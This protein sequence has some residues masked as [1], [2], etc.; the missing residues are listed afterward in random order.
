MLVLD[1]TIRISIGASLEHK[2]FRAVRAQQTSQVPR[3]LVRRLR[4][5][6]ASSLLS[7]EAMKV[8][9]RQLPSKAISNLSVSPRQSY[10][11]RLDPQSTGFITAD[12][13]SEALD[14]NGYHMAVE[15][16]RQIVNTHS[17]LGQGRIK[18]SDFL[19]ATLDRREI[20]DEENLWIAFNYFD[21][22]SV[23]KLTIVSIFESLVRAGCNVS[24]EDIR[25]ISAEFG[26][27][28]S[29]SLNFE[30]F[31][32]VML[33]INSLSPTTSEASSPLVKFMTDNAERTKQ[34]TDQQ[35]LSTD[36]RAVTG[37][38]SYFSRSAPITQAVHASTDERGLVIKL[39]PFV[40]S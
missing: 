2:W 27:S 40:D 3:K 19:I 17:L 31:S 36:R 32:R 21:V 39:N 29:D 1:P 33:A 25:Y 5:S 10:F 18:Y 16:I 11:T 12:G 8:I 23:G 24:A 6:Q 4:Q 15:D 20:L 28:R 26:I 35:L 37:W 13:L 9:V 34:P 30:S 7:R 14:N 38:E 22:E